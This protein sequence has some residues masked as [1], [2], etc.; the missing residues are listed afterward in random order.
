[1]QQLQKAFWIMCNSIGN[2]IELEPEADKVSITHTAQDIVGILRLSAREQNRRH[3]S[4]YSPLWN[5]LAKYW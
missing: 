3:T 1:M 2:T 4:D 5:I